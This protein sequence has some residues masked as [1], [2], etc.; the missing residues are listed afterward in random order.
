MKHQVIVQAESALCSIEIAA[1]DYRCASDGRPRSRQL[2]RPCRA[3][4]SPENPRRNSQSSKLFK[5][6]GAP[7]GG[8]S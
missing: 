5:G 3:L 7:T 6:N 2:T 8:S 4:G 1:T